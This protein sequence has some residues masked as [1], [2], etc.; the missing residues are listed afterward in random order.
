MVR[1]AAARMRSTSSLKLSR[2]WRWIQS[3][4]GLARPSGTTAHASSQMHPCPAGG[5]ALVLAQR[6]LAGRPSRSPSHPSIGCTAIR[7]GTVKLPNCTGVPRTV[8]MVGKRDI[9]VKFG[10]FCLEAGR[11]AENGSVRAKTCATL[12][13]A[14]N[15]EIDP[16]HS[17]MTGGCQMRKSR[18]RVF[19]GCP[20]M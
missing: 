1:R 10:D 9:Q 13:V 2:L 5:K 11:D 19:N 20:K 6:Q 18:Q 7:F 17:G 16:K 4:R 12:R 3:C 15:K 8:E 14:V